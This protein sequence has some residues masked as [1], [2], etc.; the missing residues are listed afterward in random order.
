MDS[1]DLKVKSNDKEVAAALNA[2]PACVVMP[3]AV[4]AGLGEQLQD[5]QG[6]AAD[7]MRLPSRVRRLST[8]SRTNGPNS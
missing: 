7:G 1:F 2:F 6:L 4:G 5:L 8:M 3:A